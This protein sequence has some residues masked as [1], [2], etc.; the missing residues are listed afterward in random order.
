[1]AKIPSSLSRQLAFDFLE[2]FET[3]KASSY[4]SVAQQQP[5]QLNVNVTS[6]IK[7]LSL[8]IMSSKVLD[9]EEVQTEKFVWT[10]DDID[11]LRTGFFHENIRILV[12]KRASDETRKENLEWMMS[13]ETHPFSFLVLCHEEMLNPERIRAGALAAM[14]KNGL[15]T[16]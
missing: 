10:D 2:Q 5:K 14:K 13:D 3:G 9:P 15:S 7:A 6:L 11:K 16:I 8:D 12:D 1:M 4:V